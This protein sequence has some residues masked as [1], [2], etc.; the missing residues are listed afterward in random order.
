MDDT[1]SNN[2]YLRYL[3]P[4][5]FLI[6]L[7]FFIIPGGLGVGIQWSFF[8]YQ[9]TVFGNTVFPV[10]SD[11]YYILSGII[12]GKSALSALLLIIS[13]IVLVIAFFLAMANWTRMSGLFTILSGALS[14]GSC[15][16]Q[17]GFSLMTVAGGLCI[18]FGS[19]IL[20]IYGYLLYRSLPDSDGE[21]L[22]KKYDDLFLL[23]GIFL[24]YLNFTTGSFPNDTIGT[25]LL[26]F[27][28]LHDHTIYLDDATYFLNHDFYSYRFVNIGNGHY[29]SLFPLVTPLLITPLY[30]IPVLLNI[31]I[32]DS[33]I[34]VMTHISA[35]L[36]SAFAVIF[37]YVT[38]K[39]LTTQKIALLSAFIFAFATSTWSISSQTLYAHG[40]VELLLAVMLYLV[41][42]NEI[43]QSAWNVVALGICTGLFIFN[44]P[45]DAILV[46]PIAL[47]VLWYHRKEIV[48]YIS[49]GFV[50]GLPFLIYNELLFHNPLGG[51][52]Q[53]VSRLTFGV[54]TLSNFIGLLVAPNVG[55]FI[56]SPILLFSIIGFWLIKDSTKPFYTVM[57]WS[58]IAIAITILIYASFDD[59]TGGDLYGP[60]YLTGILPYLII[61]I[62]IFLDDF[63][64]KPH[65]N[66][67][68][69][70][71]IVL[72]VISV[73]VQIIGM[74]YFESSISGT[75]DKYNQYIVYDP[76]DIGNSVIINSLSHKGA[77][78]ISSQSISLNQMLNFTHTI[79][80]KSG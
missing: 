61:G 8:R 33:T 44:R 10:A 69:A 28:I 47:Y 46:I 39:Y 55:L 9:D 71:I 72:I 51:Y 1:I 80:P 77:Q 23:G 70:I 65:N 29:V 62:C 57:K 25:Q 60:R 38:C 18:P 30:A 34:L 19:L 43:Q 31:P 7:N 21:N 15:I 79:K 16:A 54:T 42:R 3:Y 5:L 13:A 56:F 76:W 14:L 2:Q 48:Y 11:L 78:S 35:A 73:F 32:I 12:T 59:W 58:V 75:Q 37:V 68:M 6:P 22:L 27:S 64:K 40:M 50:S 67:F 52:G 17:Y 20:L 66:L 74:F 53:I 49:A 41:I 63:V 45:S 24:V 4:I 26:P 36:I